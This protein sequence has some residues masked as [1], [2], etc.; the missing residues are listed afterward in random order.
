M[1]YKGFLFL[2]LLLVGLS[3]KEDENIIPAHVLDRE[4]FSDVIVDFTLAESAAGINVLNVQGQKID[5]V[6]SFNPLLDNNI[7]QAQFD[8]SLYFYSHHPKLFREVYEIAL[9]KLSRLQASRK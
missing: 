7:T 2:S 9:E 6:Y 1:Q 8:T 3:C 4:N 5:T